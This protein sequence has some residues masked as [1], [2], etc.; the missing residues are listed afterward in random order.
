MFVCVSSSKY[1]GVVVCVVVLLQEKGVVLKPPVRKKI[2]T[3]C[4]EYSMA[5]RLNRLEADVS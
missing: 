3:Y 1:G 5:L 2:D 4:I